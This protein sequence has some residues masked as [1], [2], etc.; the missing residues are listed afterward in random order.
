MDESSSSQNRRS[1]R[2]NVLMSATVEFDGASVKA[3]LRNLSKEGALVE[4]EGLPAIGQLVTFRKGDLRL[5]GNVAW[6]AG[7]RAGIAFDQPLDPESVLR[8]V[9]A[10]RPRMAADHRRP[11]LRGQELTPGERKIAEDWIFGVPLPHVGD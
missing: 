1:R 4:G 9:P 8:H 3:K 11:R 10:P 2:S 7:N 5:S 6:R